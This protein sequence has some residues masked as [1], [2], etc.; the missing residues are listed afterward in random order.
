MDL[1]RCKLSF[2]E[3]IEYD[4]I[5]QRFE[6]KWKD[7]IH[8]A[9]VYLDPKHTDES[10]PEQSMDSLLGYFLP[11]EV[12][13]EYF[14][15]VVPRRGVHH[16]DRMGFDRSAWGIRFW[17]STKAQL[18]EAVCGS[19]GVYHKERDKLEASTTAM[20]TGLIPVVTTALKL[21]PDSAGLAI[22]IVLFIAKIGVRAFCES[23]KPSSSNQ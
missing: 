17:D 13:L 6:P 12:E 18:R 21:P 9:F 10:P 4:P 1:T 5:L 20:I 7:Q 3:A 15:G 16:F 19:K 14:K 22:I 8:K 2:E 23:T 11:P